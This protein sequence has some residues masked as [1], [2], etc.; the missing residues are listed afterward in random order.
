MEKKLDLTKPVQTRDG[1]KARIICTD[2]KSLV[3]DDRTIVVLVQSKHLPN[4]EYP[5]FLRKDG[6]CLRSL[7][8]CNDIVNVPPPTVKLWGAVF[9]SRDRLQ[10]WSHGFRTEEQREQACKSLHLHVVARFE[11][12]VEL[13]HE[14]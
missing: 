9:Q 7:E 4:K 6:R 2:F 3:S 13:P 10:T 14:I 5:V 11:S 1:R 12:E 8:S